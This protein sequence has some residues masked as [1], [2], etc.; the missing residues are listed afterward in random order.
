MAKSIILIDEFVLIFNFVISK[1][2]IIKHFNPLYNFFSKE[3][4]NEKV[5]IGF[6]LTKLS[7]C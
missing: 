2:T 1:G 7:S 6:L 4:W 3:K 5:E